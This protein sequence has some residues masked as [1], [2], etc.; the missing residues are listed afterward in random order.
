MQISIKQRKLG[1]PIGETLLGKTVTR[2]SGT[3]TFFRWINANVCGVSIFY[4][5]FFI[6]IPSSFHRGLRFA[7]PDFFFLGKASLII[8]FQKKK[9]RKKT[10]QNQ[11]KLKKKT[12][13]KKPKEDQTEQ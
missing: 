2:S 13:P 10:D 5:P 3:L 1:D 12:K 4:I 6:F 8:G 7:N 9:M 11:S